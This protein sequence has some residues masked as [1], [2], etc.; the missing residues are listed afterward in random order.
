MEISESGTGSEGIFLG[1]AVTRE[2][3]RERDREIKRERE[4]NGKRE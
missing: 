2:R 4:G 1:S 3:V